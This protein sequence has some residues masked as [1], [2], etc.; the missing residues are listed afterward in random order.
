MSAHI[1]YSP[2]VKRSGNLFF[3]KMEVG[4]IAKFSIKTNSVPQSFGVSGDIEELINMRIE[5]YHFEKELNVSS[6]KN[7]FC[8]VYDDKNL[9]YHLIN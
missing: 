3:S 9:I 4:K 2:V 7:P 5:G 6:F 8:V 1:N